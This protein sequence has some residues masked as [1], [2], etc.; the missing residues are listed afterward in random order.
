MFSNV[1]NTE[2]RNTL[3]LF[4]ESKEQNMLSVMVLT[5]MGQLNTNNFIFLF[6][7]FSDFIL[8]LFSYFFYFSFG[9]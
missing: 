7:Y 6:F 2:N 9:R 4:V 5:V 3:L 8:I 1:R